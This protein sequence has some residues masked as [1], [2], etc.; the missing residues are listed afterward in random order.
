MKSG[1]TVTTDNSVA[2]L[3]SLRQ[4]SGMDV[5]VGI[6]A[7]SASRE[8]GSKLNN[9]EIGYLQ[10][11]GATVEIDGTIV[12]L[13]PRPFLDM[14]IEESKPRTTEHLKAAAIAALDGKQDAAMRELESAGQIARDAS[15]TVISSGDQLQPLSEATIKRRRASKPPIIDDKPL[16]ARGYLLRSINYIVRKK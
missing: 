10:S 3:E 9:A 7:D 15:K 11:T 8:D 5:L 13:P 4:L 14:G 12:T 2:V 6:P 1:L 16:W